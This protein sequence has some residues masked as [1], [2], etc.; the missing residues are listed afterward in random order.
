MID[1]TRCPI[2]SKRACKIFFNTTSLRMAL[3]RI[4]EHRGAKHYQDCLYDDS[5]LTMAVLHQVLA[6]FLLFF[7]FC[8]FVYEN[9]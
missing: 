4:R 5:E 2:Y 6:G 1:V 8:L 3:K 9:A 7:C